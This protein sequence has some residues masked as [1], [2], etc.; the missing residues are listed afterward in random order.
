MAARALRLAVRNATV[1]GGATDPRAKDVAGNALA[2]NASW[3][4]TTAAAQSACP[5]SI[6]PATATPAN[7][8]IVDSAALNLGVKFMSDVSGHISGIRFYKGSGN[9]GTHV[10]HLWT[11][12]GT[13]LASATFAEA[14]DSGWQQV[15]LA[16][17][18]SLAAN[19]RKDWA[20]S[21]RPGIMRRA[22]PRPQEK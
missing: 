17:P 4:F 15:N 13:L 1:V 22:G 10:G 19:S 7:P 16:S 12:G 21:E 5:C 8:A 2:A 9:T 14:T 11:S 18:V 6:W 3:S 20:S